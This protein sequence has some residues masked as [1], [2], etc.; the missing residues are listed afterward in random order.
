MTEIILCNQPINSNM[1]E[2]QCGVTG[3]DIM[4]FGCTA[5]PTSFQPYRP[6]LVGQNPSILD[7]SLLG[8][9]GAGPTVQNLTDLSLSFGEDNTL[10]LAEITAKLREYNIGMVGASTSIY[11]NRVQGFGLAVKK[12]QDALMEYRKAIKSSP[13]SST[14]ARQKAFSAFQQM[15]NRFRNELAAVTAAS[16]ARKGTPLGNPTRAT[17]IARSSRNVAKL[18]VTSQVQA[19][20]LVKYSRYA[21]YLGNGLAIIDFGTRVGNIHSSYKADGDWERELF[22]E[23]S[24]FALSAIVGAVT[25]KAGLALL[26]V[27]TPVGWVGL[28]VG[29]VAVAGTAAAASIAMN[30]AV[31]NSSGGV[32]DEIMTWLNLK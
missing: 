1:M 13:A 29:G 11:A 25:V 30:S 26:I 19:S 27:A 9:L 17:N 2:S 32:Y 22:I 18:N 16:K 4:G 7:R 23:S 14:L 10:A 24:S 15:Q 20:N 6:Y 8:Q 12:Y 3:S 21:K 28:I 31:Q 5:S